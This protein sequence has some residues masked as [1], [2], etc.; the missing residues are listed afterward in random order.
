MRLF[1]DDKK[2]LLSKDTRIFVRVFFYFISKGD[3]PWT[4]D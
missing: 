3:L 4:T 2:T 1:R